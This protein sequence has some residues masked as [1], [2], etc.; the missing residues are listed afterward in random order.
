MLEIRVLGS[1]EVIREGVPTALPPS[2]KTR[3]LL[4]YLA[5]VRGRHRREQLCELFWEVPDDP[6]GSLRWS[7]SKIRSIVDHVSEPRL[8][9]DRQSVELCTEL[10]GVD[11]HAAQSYAARTGASTDDLLTVAS[12]F[13]GPLLSDLDL[14]ENSGFHTWLLGVREDARKLQANILRSLI[15]RLSATPEEALPYAREL[16]GVDPFDE[17]AW[18][19]LI[20]TLAAAGRGGE[21]RPQFE[22]G[23]R[24]LRDVGGGFGSLMRAWR[25]TQAAGRRSVDDAPAAARRQAAHRASIVVLPFANLSNDPAQQYFADGITCELTTDLSRI[26]DMLVISRNTAF[27]YRNRPIDTRQIGRELGV[28]CLLEG[29]VQRSGEEVRVTVQLID[30]ESDAHLWAERFSGE[31]GDLFALQ[32]QITR[33]IAVA[34]DLEL[35]DVEASRQIETPDTRDYIMRGRAARLRPPSRENRAEQ[36]LL[37]EQALAL[38]PQSIGAQ[39]WLAIELAARAVDLMT[40]TPAADIARAEGLAK[41]AAGM[42]PRYSVAR[43]AMAQVLRSQHRY[44]EAIAEY[45][46]V[47]ALNRN[48][49][50]AYSHLGWCKFMT[51]LIE[52]LIPAQEE[53]IRLSPRDPQIGL[54]YSRIGRAHLLQSRIDE[55]VIWC[56]K[57]CSATP[58]AAI[59]RSFLASASALK[60][61]TQRATAELAEA[62]R[63]VADDRYLSIARV[64]A[65]TPWGAPTIR[66]LAEATYLAGLRMAGMPED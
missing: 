40:D 43:F 14:P 37:F 66:D 5:L 53:A 62:R 51:G 45:E 13:R 26:P 3:A 32:D 44:D 8:L 11:F 10:A 48:W 65:I 64:R 58:A 16:V 38:D 56:E 29:E 55:A 42:A 47:I 15:E 28:H 61:D 9:A 20:A 31:A 41:R 23:L 54:F 46:A 18:A 1:L 21:L 4:A 30:A 6:R 50:H 49:A 27:S 34:L 35:V 2:R 33:R 17:D 12:S 59:F 52:E 7:L 22:A 57:A 19:L 36:V 63:L 24:T 60:G 25:A 39:S